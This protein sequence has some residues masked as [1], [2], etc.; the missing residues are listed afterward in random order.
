M[1][2]RALLVAYL[3][4][5]ATDTVLAAAGVDGPRWVSKTLLMPVLIAFVWAAA[6]PGA[7]RDPWLPIGALVGGFVGDVGLLVDREATFMIGMA[8][9]AVGHVCYLL[10]F[11]RMGAALSAG[12]AVGY[13]LAWGATMALV[14]R[15]LDE[16]LVPVLGYSLLL[17]AMAAYAAGA[18][19][20]TGLG[21]ALFLL[22]D[23]VI[24]LGIADVD[25]VP[26]QDAVVM[27][28]YVAAQLL[29]V[30]TWATWPFAR[31]NADEAADRRS[32]ASSG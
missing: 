28:T 27:P 14:W 29:L 12:R 23:A 24:A 32:A 26:G 5:G 25:L 3:T 6:R 20:R 4:L 30:L 10:A 9:F 2:A 7:G 13:L 22:S 18:G 21:G 31:R 19:R 17:T 8:G 16:L 15:G 11:G 1:R